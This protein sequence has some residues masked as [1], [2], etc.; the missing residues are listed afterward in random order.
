M[1]NIGSTIQ[2]ASKTALSIAVLVYVV[3]Y[4]WMQYASKPLGIDKPNL[5]FLKNGAL[6]VAY[7]SLLLG[8]IGLYVQKVEDKTAVLQKDLPILGLRVGALLTIPWLVKNWEL[9]NR[10][11]MTLF[12]ALGGVGAWLLAEFL[13]KRA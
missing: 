3:Q 12:V 10:A 5:D 6:L 4:L 9:Q 2:S 8:P 7:A 1:S 11:P 13:Q